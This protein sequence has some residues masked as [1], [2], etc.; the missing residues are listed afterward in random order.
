MSQIKI[1]WYN[2]EEDFLSDGAIDIAIRDRRTNELVA[3]QINNLEDY[4]KLVQFLDENRQ[5]GVLS[6]LDVANGN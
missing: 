1:G 4:D 5:L 2:L 6:K 3:F